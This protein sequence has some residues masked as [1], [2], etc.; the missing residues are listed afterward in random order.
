MSTITY[1]QKGLH[2]KVYLNGASVG[3][4]MMNGKGFRYVPNGAKGNAAKGETLVSVEA[5]KRSLEVTGDRGE[6]YYDR[7][8]AT[9][10][11]NRAE[12]FVK[13]ETK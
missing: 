13:L 5:V 6:V 4:I 11:F 7:D 10:D 3:T 1:K 2:A 9:G 8:N 12:N